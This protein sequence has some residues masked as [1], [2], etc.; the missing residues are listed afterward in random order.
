MQY[1]FKGLAI[2]LFKWQYRFVPFKLTYFNT[3]PQQ[4]VHPKHITNKV[5]HWKIPYTIGLCYFLRMEKTR[6]LAIRGKLFDQFLLVYINK[7]SKNI[8]TRQNHDTKTHFHWFLDC[9]VQSD[10]EPYFMITLIVGH[11]WNITG[12]LSTPNQI[13]LQK[14]WYKLFTNSM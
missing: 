3:K 9:F 14:E 7:Q 12:M 6:L 13:A 1:P 11:K 8:K 10:R 4:T 5:L 2:C